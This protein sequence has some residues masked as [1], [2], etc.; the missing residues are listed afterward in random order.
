MVL[1]TALM[2]NR[3]LGETC[4]FFAAWMGIYPFARRTWAAGVP[5]RR[6]LAG[7]VMAAAI[8]AALRIVEH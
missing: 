2:P 6:Y 4:G 5:F 1:V 8:G 7:G 3:L